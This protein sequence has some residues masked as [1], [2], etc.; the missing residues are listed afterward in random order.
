MRIREI[1]EAKGW[2]QEQL[3]IAMSTTQQT[4]QRWE[5]ERTDVKSNQLKDLSRVLGVTVSY[6]LGI[7]EGVDDDRLSVDERN[8]VELYRSMDADKRSTLIDTARAFAALSEKDGGACERN[9]VARAMDA[10]R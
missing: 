4:I 3:A 5:S 10:V 1:R 9:K 7:D 6:L 2:T 8:L